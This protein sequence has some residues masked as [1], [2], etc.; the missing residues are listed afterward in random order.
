LP[1]KIRVHE[2]AKELGLPL[3]QVMAKLQELNQPVK[4]P[5]STIEAPIVKV[6][7]AE[8]AGQ[9][10]AHEPAIPA[11]PRFATLPLAGIPRSG[12]PRREWYRGPQ[13]AELTTMILDRIV[14]RRRSPFSSRP[15]GPSRYF[16]DEV[17]DAQVLAAEWSA[18]LFEGLSTE[19]IV[20]WMQLA[21]PPISFRQA[22]VLHSAQIT[23]DDLVSG[24]MNRGRPSLGFRLGCG[25]IT[26]EQIVVEVNRRRGRQDAAS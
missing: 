18:A 25:N 14:I 10:K 26:V 5:S 16:A 17:K 7:K 1:N 13:P 8:F 4:S 23:P 6:L 12:R 9:P 19:D 3:K 2:L 15:S 24:E 20:D 21:D 22:L 11:P